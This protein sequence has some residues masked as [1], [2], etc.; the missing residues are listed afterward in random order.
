MKH[1][2][3]GIKSTRAKPPL[4]A[5]AVPQPIPQINVPIIPLGQEIRAYLRA[6]YGRQQD[7]HMM[8]MNEVPV[9]RP[10]LI[11]MDDND[12]TIANVFC[13][14]ASADK[15][16]SIIY[17]D[18][19]GSFPFVSLDGS[20]CF[21]VLYHYESNCILATLIKGMDDKTIF[22]A[23]K[24]Y[25]EELTSK[26]FKPKL[27]VMDNQAIKHINQYLSENECKLQLVEPHNHRVN[28]AERAIQ[29]FMDAFIA[30]LA[31]TDVGFPLKL[32]NKLTPQVQSC[33]N[34][35]RRSCLRYRP[36]QIG[37][38]NAISLPANFRSCEYWHI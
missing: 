1:P 7:P 24:K 36:F 6:A 4:P 26:G 9:Q 14:G 8:E 21:F 27:N 23:C 29:T 19:T 15:T 16:N 12:A 18:L 35:M 28:A 3:H 2:R 33:L 20:M 17:N 37:I 34:L 11:G 25:F 13:F 30:A 32:W 10:N 31:T 5:T 38:Q 22:E